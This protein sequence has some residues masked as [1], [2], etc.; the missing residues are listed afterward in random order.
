MKDT[1]QIYKNYLFALR[2]K[3]LHG[4]KYGDND[5]LIKIYEDLL[6]ITPDNERKNE[7][8]TIQPKQK[9]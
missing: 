5:E 4:D 8:E 6:G 3:Q 1:L 9:L 2:E 7:N